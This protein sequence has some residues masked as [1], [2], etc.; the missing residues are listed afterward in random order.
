MHLII[1]NKLYSSW[2][3]RPWLMLKA[4]DIPFEETVIA[5]RQPDTKDRIR[6]YSPTGLVPVLIDGD[7]V[8]WESVAILSHL[9]DV[10]PDKPVWPQ[11]K[12]ARAHAKSISLEM[13]AGFQAL[14]SACPMNL[15]KRFAPRDFGPDV[16]ANIERLE[17]MWRDA[18]ARFAGD[19][20]PFLFGSFSAADAMYAPV[21]TRL[22]TYSF[23]VAD[24]TRAYMDAVLSHPA[25]QA[26]RTDAL[27]EPWTIDDYEAGHTPIEDFRAAAA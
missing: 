23:E 13:H 11:G 3:M 4:L 15:G 21:A 26:W 22:D 18:R 6:A 14:R 27:K 19:S 5:M 12:A 7:A 20:E 1:V 9:A 10:F 25:F 17:D 16:A 2:S 8:V 24:D